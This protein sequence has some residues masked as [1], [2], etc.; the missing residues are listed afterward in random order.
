MHWISQGAH[1]IH[2]SRA[3]L[4]T[5]TLLTALA[6]SAA[7][8]KRNRDYWSPGPDEHGDKILVCRKGKNGPR[9]IEIN[10]TQR[11]MKIDGRS[12][13]IHILPNRMAEFEGPGIH[14]IHWS[15]PKQFLGAGGHNELTI[16]G[17]TERYAGCTRV[18][19]P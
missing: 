1:W 2:I 16:N 15:P 7:V 9:E 12:I 11:S 17:Q 14:W 10:F 3:V 4:V 19:A 5:S 8:A 13:P 6:P 18:N